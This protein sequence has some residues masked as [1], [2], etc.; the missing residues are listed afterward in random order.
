M[1]V[2]ICSAA[3]HGHKW[4]GF[5]VASLIDNDNSKE[6]ITT[7]RSRNRYVRYLLLVLVAL[8]FRYKFRLVAYFAGTKEPTGFWMGLAVSSDF[9][10]ELTMRC[11]L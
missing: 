3:E 11:E 8:E 6:T 10:I 1:S 2:V 4:T 7:R 5:I 9:R